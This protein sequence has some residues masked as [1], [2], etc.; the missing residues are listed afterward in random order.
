MR[1]RVHPR[2]RGPGPDR[3]AQDRGKQALPWSRALGP[4]MLRACPRFQARL[5]ARILFTTELEGEDAEQAVFETARRYVQLAASAAHDAA[6]V[7]PD[8]SPHVVA[9][10]AVAS[11]AERVAPV[12]LPQLSGA[13]GAFEAAGPAPRRTAPRSE[14]PVRTPRP[15]DHP[16]RDL[17]GPGIDVNAI[18]RW[19]LEQ[20]ARALLTRL[21]RIRPFA[22]QETMLPA[23]ALSPPAQIAIER[24][25][26][27]N[28]YQLRQ[29]VIALPAL[30]AR[31]RREH[32][33]VRDAAAVHDRAAAL[34]RRADP[35]RPLLRTDH[36][37]QRALHRRL[38]AALYAL[39]A[40]AMNL[41]RRLLR[42]A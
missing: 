19:A 40:D 15:P 13:G 12:L 34:Q 26:I 42:A 28:R 6:L 38:L 18:A 17:T 20:E 1:G 10:Q 21:G 25:L 35:V 9:Q 32:A 5:P 37:A 14:R 41:A 4:K 22:L 11:A 3:S 36:A 24:F 16:V 39:A 7:P 27:G 8:I 29:E 33:A 31:H 30:A 23:A 2:P